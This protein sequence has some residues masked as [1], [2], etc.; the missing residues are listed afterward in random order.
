MYVY[1]N[2]GIVIKNKSSR[3]KW[4]LDCNENYD[5]RLTV[6]HSAVLRSFTLSSNITLCEFSIYVTDELPLTV[7]N[8]IIGFIW[9]SLSIELKLLCSFLIFLDRL[10]TNLASKMARL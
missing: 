8:K 3:T 10:K 4:T 7:L 9:L 2:V 5:D 6:L 1:L